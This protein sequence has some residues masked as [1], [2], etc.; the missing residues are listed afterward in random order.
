MWDNKRDPR[1]PCFH[2][3]Y[4]N[5][6]NAEGTSGADIDFLSNGF[7]Q[8]RTDSDQNT[9]SRNYT[10]MAFAEH[11]FIGDGTNPVTAR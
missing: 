1:N 2:R 6:A 5:L 9:S 11:P 7:K 3:S 10:Y 4:A 8:R